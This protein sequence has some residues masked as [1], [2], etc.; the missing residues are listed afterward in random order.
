MIQ[1]TIFVGLDVHKD[2]IAVAVANG[3]GGAPAPLAP[4]IPGRRPCAIWSAG[5]GRLSGSPP[6]TRRGRVGIRS[7]AT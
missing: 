2:S 3:H 5:S 4:S 1:D 7:I 6:A